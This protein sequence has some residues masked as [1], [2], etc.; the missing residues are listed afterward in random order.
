MYKSDLEGKQNGGRGRREDER[1]KENERKKDLEKEERKVIPFGKVIS[2][3][4]RKK[5]ERKKF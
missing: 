2:Q 5:N 4:G 3:G 1:Q